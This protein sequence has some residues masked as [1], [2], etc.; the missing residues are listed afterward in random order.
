MRTLNSNPYKAAREIAKK[1]N[2]QRNLEFYAPTAEAKFLGPLG[3][4]LAGTK[5]V[6]QSE[7][8]MEGKEQI[9]YFRALHYLK[10]LYRTLH[11]RRECTRRAVLLMVSLRNR[12]VLANR[13]LIY[14]M[15]KRKRLLP[16]MYDAVLPEAEMCLMRSVN[17]FDPWRGFEFSTY[18]CRGINT[19]IARVFTKRKREYSDDPQSAEFDYKLNQANEGADPLESY[20]LEQL[21]GQLV[22]NQQGS[23][24]LAGLNPTESLVIKWRFGLRCR[25]NRQGQVLTLERLGE[26]LGV[27]KE[28]VRQI[29]LRGLEKLRAHMGSTFGI[30]H[31]AG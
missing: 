1:Y 3:L 30:E 10:Y 21:K 27:S 28:R 13:G 31:A 16:E 24:F 8:Q 29:E 18:A 5:L 25:A 4:T 20:L 2:C 15:C 22:V 12:L 11:K 14:S 26:R 17:R 23:Y 19:A 7:E 6:Q 9:V